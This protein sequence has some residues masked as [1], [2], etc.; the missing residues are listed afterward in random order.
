[1][2][3]PDLF[4]HKPLPILQFTMPTMSR[5]TVISRNKYLHL[6]LDPQPD[7]AL[8][9]YFFSDNRQFTD[10]MLT[11]LKKRKVFISKAR[12]KMILEERDRKKQGKHM[13]Y[14]TYNDLLYFEGPSVSLLVSIL[15][16]VLDYN[17]LQ[18]K[19]DAQQFLC[20]F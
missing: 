14:D 4:L 16:A 8:K 6:D 7:L 2:E 12:I 11:I 1:V 17:A 20:F 19:D 3:E 18:H 5:K 10:H 15:F 9:M 13:F